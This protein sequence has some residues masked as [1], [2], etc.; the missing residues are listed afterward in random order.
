MANGSLPRPAAHRS[1]AAHPTARDG[2]QERR[3]DWD[4]ELEFI[5]SVAEAG[6]TW[7]QEWVPPSELEKTREAISRE[8]LR[9][10]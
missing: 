5:R 4:L 2:G 6:A 7:W 9:I 3:A 8:P 10:D 1:R